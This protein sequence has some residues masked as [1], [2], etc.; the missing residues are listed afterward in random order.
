MSNLELLKNRFIYLATLLEVDANEKQ[1]LRYKIN[2]TWKI[3]YEYLGKNKDNLM[4]DDDFLRNHWIMYFKFNKKEANAYAKFLLNK[5]FTAKNIIEWEL[6]I[7]EIENYIKSLWKVVKHWFYL[8]NPQLSYFSDETKEW[9]QK[10]NRLGMGSFIPLLIA[11]LIKNEEKEI[12][13]LLKSIERFIFLIFKITKRPSNTKSSYFYRLANK[14]YF[15]EGWLVLSDV[16]EEITLL[17]KDESE[18]S[19]NGRTSLNKFKDY[20]KELFNKYEWFYSRGWL[21]YFL[22][23]YELDLQQKA[24]GN[25]KIK[26]EDFTKRKKENTIE[27]IYPQTPKDNCWLEKFNN[28]YSKKDVNL[29]LHSLW[30]LV[31]LWQSKNSSLQNKCF[32][33]KKKDTKN[34]NKIW[35]FNG[36]YSEINIAEKDERTPESIQKRWIELLDFLEKRWDIDFEKCGVVKEDILQL[37]F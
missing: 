32:N 23:E 30:N 27:H 4:S 31:L 11:A 19:D 21:N 22:F 37:N 18:D 5:K 9:I 29:L 25:I 8:Q 7:D 17:S 34:W 13:L 3:I 36:S 16:I 10:L 12:L 35:F 1:N 2:E 33:L 15:W 20:I 6:Q 14:L 24:N 28:K 26:R